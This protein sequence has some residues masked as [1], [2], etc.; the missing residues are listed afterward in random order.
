MKFLI[1]RFSS[2]GDI[3]VTSP[4]MR[5]LKKKFPD[6]EIHYA[7]KKEFY[8]VVQHNPYITKIH[9]LG[10]SIFSLAKELKQQKFDYIID[11]HNNQRTLLVKTLLGVKSVS[12]AKLNFEKLLITK[13]KIN[14]LPPI[15]LVDR[16]FSTCQKLGVENDGEGLDYFITPA[17]EVDIQSL[18]LQFHNGYV[19]WAIGGLH[20]TK[21]F[22]PEKVARALSQLHA[23]VVLMGG[24]DDAANAAAIIMLTQNKA[25]F[26]AC[27]LYTLNQSASLVRQARMMVTNDTSLMHIAAAFKRPV[28]SIWGNTIPQFGMGPYYGKQYLLQNLQG[29]QPRVFEVQGLS[30]RPC[31]RLGYSACPQGHFNCMN[32]I[33][34]FEIAARVNT[35]YNL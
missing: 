6:A 2:I 35:D 21:R 8:P 4:V 7:T 11:L 14:K 13:F 26:N 23:P 17:D 30:C 29:I 27:G 12:V 10:D 3:V 25:V 28:F 32:R 9:F 15:H 22:P 20:F 5:C 34:E 31:S 24:K 33:D 16:F 19:G 18:P 1:L